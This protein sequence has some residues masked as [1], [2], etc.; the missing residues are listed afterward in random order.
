MTWKHLYRRNE[1][2]WLNAGGFAWF[3]N[4]VTPPAVNHNFSRRDNM[5]SEGFGMPVFPAREK[6]RGAALYGIDQESW[7]LRSPCFSFQSDGDFDM[8]KPAF[9]LPGVDLSP[10]PESPFVLNQRDI[11][12]GD[13]KWVFQLPM[14]TGEVGPCTQLLNWWWKKW[15]ELVDIVD[16]TP[17]EDYPEGFMELAQ[18]ISEEVQELAIEIDMSNCHGAAAHVNYI[19]NFMHTYTPWELNLGATPEA[20]WESV[21]PGVQP[22]E[23]FGDRFELAKYLSRVG[24]QEKNPAF[25]AVFNYAR[26]SVEDPETKVTFWPFGNYICSETGFTW[27]DYNP[28]PPEDYIPPPIDFSDI[29]PSIRERVKEA[30]GLSLEADAQGSCWRNNSSVVTSS[31]NCFYMKHTGRRKLR[32]RIT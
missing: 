32:I 1:L 31:S 30:E 6:M 23:T 28:T 4:G 29:I 25:E 11:P 26:G 5:D 7:W 3:L 19:W 17:P 8:M 27:D 9:A 2:S 20:T 12:K 15:Q 13:H 18:W 22:G 16:S 21:W 24:F 10:K 14:Y